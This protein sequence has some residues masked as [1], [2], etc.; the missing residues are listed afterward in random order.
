MVKGS[1]SPAVSWEAP[2]YMF[3]AAIPES[4]AS[5]KIPPGGISSAN[6]EVVKRAR[7][8]YGVPL[9]PN[10]KKQELAEDAARLYYPQRAMDLLRA[11]DG[12]TLS[13][14]GHDRP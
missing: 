1:R 14:T 2:P 6:E 12:M 3:H 11:P 5:G 8:A 9:L 10:P 13:A 4:Q 7:L